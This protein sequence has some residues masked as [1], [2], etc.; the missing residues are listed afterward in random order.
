MCIWFPASQL[1]LAF[2]INLF[3]SKLVRTSSDN[4]ASVFYNSTSG[5][6]EEGQISV[7]SLVGWQWIGFATCIFSTLSSIVLT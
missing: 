5:D 1:P 6:V 7:E 2:G 3:F 4:M